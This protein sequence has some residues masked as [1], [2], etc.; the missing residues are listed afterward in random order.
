MDT[1]ADEIRSEID[2]VREDLGDTLEQIG[3]RVAPN[4][5]VARTKADLVM[6]VDEVKDKVSPRRLASRGA[7]AVRRGVRTAV[8][9]DGT[10]SSAGGGRLPEVAGYFN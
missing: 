1:R 5:V 4:K 7:D 10:T 9:S 3:D 6:K 2:D 8:G